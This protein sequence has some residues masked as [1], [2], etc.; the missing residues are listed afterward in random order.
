[1]KRITSIIG[2]GAL[3]LA[4]S[5]SSPKQSVAD[6]NADQKNV[7]IEFTGADT[8]A[9]KNAKLKVSLYGVSA[10][11]A[12]VPATLITEKNT[13]KKLFLLLLIFRCLLILKALLSRLL[14]R[15]KL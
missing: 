14:L 9:V 2:I 5:C 11:I 7:K 12:D 13:N 3:L 1:M 10:N 8:F 4:S 6:K 15:G